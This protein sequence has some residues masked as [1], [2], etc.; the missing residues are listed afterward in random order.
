LILKLAAF[1]F[2]HLK[3]PL[4]ISSPQQNSALAGQDFAPDLMTVDFSNQV[5]LWIECGKTTLHKLDKVTKRFRE[6]RLWMLLAYPHEAK[7]MA[8]SLESEGNKR[9]EVWTFKQGE[10]DRWKS[11]VQENNDIVGEATE[12]SMNLVIN[13]EMFMTDLERIRPDTLRV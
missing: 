11:L 5:T 2:F 10:Y 7:Q 4:I 1:I 6:A 9:F 12:T 13:S 3:E 8:E